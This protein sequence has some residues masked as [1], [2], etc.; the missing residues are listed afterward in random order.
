MTAAVAA[1]L[2][3]LAVADG[4][5]AGF[6]ASAGRTGLIR[7]RRSD[8]RAAVRGAGLAGVLLAP[9]LAVM[10]AEAVRPGGLEDYARAGTAM[11][12]IYGPAAL[13]VLVALAGYTVLS[14]RLRYLASALVLGPFT[15]LRPGVAILG[16]AVGAAE[17]RDAVVAASVVLSVIAVLAVEPLAGRLWYAPAPGAG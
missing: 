3:L 14:W 17:S 9:V 16:A 2:L 11:L 13:V 6:R 1:V 5:F 12:A 8:Y 15:L 10:C 4:A 7:H